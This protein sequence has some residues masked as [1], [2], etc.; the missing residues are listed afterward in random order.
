MTLSLVVDNAPPPSISWSELGRLC[1]QG[2]LDADPTVARRM[3][4]AGLSLARMWGAVFPQRGAVHVR[5]PI[6]L[7]P[8]H[9]EMAESDLR[10]LRNFFGVGRRHLFSAVLNCVA[11]DE[12][13]RGPR[14]SAIREGL[15]IIIEWQN[16]RKETAS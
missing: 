5:N 15:Q 6:T 2:A 16:Q 12:R 10:A 7:E 9:I 8:G 1:E 4:D 14:L 3:Y 11:Y 13:P